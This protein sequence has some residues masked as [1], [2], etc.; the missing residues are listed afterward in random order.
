[1]HGQVLFFF[2]KN[3]IKMYFQDTEREG[4]SWVHLGQDTGTNTVCPCAHGNDSL[5]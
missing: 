2:R 1:M 4:V 5:W 3:T